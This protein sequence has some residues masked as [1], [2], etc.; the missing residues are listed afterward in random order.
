MEFKSGTTIEFN[1]W[2]YG[3]NIYVTIPSNDFQCTKGLCGTFDGIKE[4]EL[5]DYHGMNR[6][7]E[8]P[9]HLVAPSSFTE[10]WK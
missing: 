5:I 8:L 10:S 1:A 7:N 9:S 2:S 6:K 3:A 4:N